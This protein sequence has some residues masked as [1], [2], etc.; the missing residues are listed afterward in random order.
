MSLHPDSFNP[1]GTFV[2]EWSFEIRGWGTNEREAWEHAIE[3]FK[4]NPDELP[5]ISYMLPHDY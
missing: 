5:K 2:R 3:R 4:A 1:D